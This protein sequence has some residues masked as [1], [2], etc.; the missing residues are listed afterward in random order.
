MKK[1]PFKWGLERHR[2]W[3]WEK[4]KDGAKESVSKGT[5]VGLG[6]E[7]T[8]NTI[9]FTLVKWGAQEG[10]QWGVTWQMEK[11]LNIQGATQVFG[12]WRPMITTRRIVLDER[13][14]GVQ[15]GSQT[16]PL[17]RASWALL[18]HVT[19]SHDTEWEQYLMPDDFLHDHSEIMT[20]MVAH[21]NYT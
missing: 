17:A 10:C 9:K 6:R 8:G 21:F 1:L 7:Y 3:V 4:G 20:A 14:T 11:V 5:T 12:A 19:V 2:L 13:K 15:E 16:L 18:N